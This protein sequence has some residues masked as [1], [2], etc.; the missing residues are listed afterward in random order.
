MK[1]SKL[2]TNLVNYINLKLNPFIFNVSMYKR[3]TKNF[4]RLEKISKVLYKFTKENP[5][6][7]SS[8]SGDSKKIPL[9]HRWDVLT[10]PN[11]DL[12]FT[13]RHSDKHLEVTVWNLNSLR[14]QITY[15]QILLCNN[16]QDVK[17]SHLVTQ[18]MVIVP[19][20]Q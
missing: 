10:C 18:I 9:N 17:R 8:P 7:K 11:R 1:R 12:Q 16:I 5:G 19:C 2:L 6:Y 15:G 14:E 13:S 20:T 3:I 4:S